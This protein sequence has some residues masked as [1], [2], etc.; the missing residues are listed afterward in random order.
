MKYSCGQCR[1]PTWW[2]LIDL[3][4]LVLLCGTEDA[5]ADPHFN[6]Q[7]DIQTGLAVARVRGFRVI[8]RQGV[9]P[10]LSTMVRACG[11]RAWSED[12]WLKLF[13]PAT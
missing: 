13:G 3:L 12:P 9:Q 11:L 10:R 1:W 7:V 4:T 5:Y 8:H 2:I 6:K